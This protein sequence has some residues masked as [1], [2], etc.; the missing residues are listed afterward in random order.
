[1]KNKNLIYYVITSIVIITLGLSIV[2]CEHNGEKEDNKLILPGQNIPTSD[3]LMK[4]IIEVKVKLDRPLNF[5][6]IKQNPNPLYRDD[7]GLTSWRS[8]EVQIWLNPEL[9]YDDQEAVAAHELAH[10][11]Q[12]ME[13]YGVVEAQTNSQAQPIFPL[14]G[15]IASDMNSAVLD[16]NADKW[17]ADRGFKVK[18]G[19][20]SDYLP[21]VLGPMEKFPENNFEA[22]NWDSYYSWLENLAKVSINGNTTNIVFPEE[23]NTQD[24]ALQYLD[25]KMRLNPYGLFNEVDK[26]VKEKFPKTWSVGVELCNFVENEGTDNQQQCNE[27][28]IKI[29]GYLRIPYPLLLVRDYTNGNIIWPKN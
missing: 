16:G 18:E 28:M 20:I 2:S 9:K 23:I 10:V 5:Y 15:R 11:M 19:L 22:I 25:W 13:G 12:A 3:K 7:R 21:E 1:M 8:N 24:N 17:A 4:A 27:D 26:I 14:L 29:I 6:N